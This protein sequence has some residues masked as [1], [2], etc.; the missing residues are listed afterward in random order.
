[1]TELKLERGLEPH[2]GRWLGSV[3]LASVGLLLWTEG[4]ADAGAKAGREAIVHPN[5]GV[6]P[7]HVTARRLRHLKV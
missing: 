7:L 1:M 5:P 3:E 2:A 4:D 6:A